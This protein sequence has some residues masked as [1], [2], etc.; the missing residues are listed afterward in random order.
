MKELAALMVNSEDEILER[1]LEY[2]EKT[3]YTKYASRISKAWRLAVRGLTN[4][5]VGLSEIESDIPELSPDE[6]YRTG[7]VAE[8][9]ILEAR[10]H[11]ARGVTLPL[12]LGLM[13][14]NRQAFLD[15]IKNAALDREKEERYR[16]YLNRFFDRIELAFV[17]AWITGPDF[18]KNV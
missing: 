2:A 16:L 14:Y 8:F 5:L 12:F 10:V 13:K 11:S 1:L 4:S 18:S 15:V 7:P 9:V 6:D 3:G 17:S